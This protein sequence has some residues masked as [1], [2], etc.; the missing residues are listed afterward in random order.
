M[1][2]GNLVVFSA[3]VM[4]LVACGGEQ[5]STFYKIGSG[6]SGAPATTAGSDGTESRAHLPMMAPTNTT[7]AAGPSAGYGDSATTGLDEKAPVAPATGGSSDELSTG[8]SYQQYQSNLTAGQVDDNAKFSEYLDYLREYVGGVVTPIDVSQ[9]L[10]VRVLDGEQQPIAGARV[11]LF[12]GQRKV[13]E[14]STM[15]DGRALFFPSAADATQT[16]EYRAVIGR[17]QTSVEAAV[18][19]GLGEQTV[20]LDGVKDN[21]G[22]VGIDLVFLLDATGSMGDEIARIKGTVESIAQRIEQLPGSSAPRFGLVAF[23]DRGDDYVTRSWDFT[24]DVDWF[25]SNLNGVNASGGGDTAESVNAGLHDAIHLPGWADNSTGR[26]LRLIVLVGDAPPHLDY[27][28]DYSYPALLQEAVAA[29]IKIFPVGASNLES[30][31]EYI[32]R[33]FAEVTQ[34][35]FVFLTYANGVSGAPGLSTDKHVSDFTVQ[36]LDSLIVN[37]VAGEIANQTGGQQVGASD[38]QPVNV[39]APVWIEEGPP[40]KEPL[41]GLAAL[42]DDFVGGRGGIFWAAIL[43]IVGAVVL[44]TRKQIAA[45]VSPAPAQSEEIYVPEQ[46]VEDAAEQDRAMLAAHLQ[47]EAGTVQLYLDV[48]EAQQPTVP[49]R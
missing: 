43:L 6:L 19:P 45:R 47:P 35:Q 3:L 10:F 46:H 17:G 28:D 42:L 27:Q 40:V 26:R 33:Q 29:G 34:G 44:T 39:V 38:P 7:S 32:F 20:V 15:S 14:G 1:G 9:R 37:L 41:T 48:Q 36:N 5:N 13:F 4:S 21:T 18:R 2:F 49:L 12:D 31:G 16:K 25:A 30:D 8:K 24:S 22:A 11:Q 23:R